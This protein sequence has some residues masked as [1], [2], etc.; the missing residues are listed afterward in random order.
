MLWRTKPVKLGSLQG[1]Q[2]KP[3]RHDSVYEIQPTSGP[4]RLVMTT[5]RD[6][7]GLVRSLVEC[8]EPP[9]GVLY[10]LTV[11][12][13]SHQRGRYQNT[14]S[15]SRAQLDGFLARFADALAC[16][17]RHS[18]WIASTQLDGSYESQV[19][20]DQ[21]DFVYAYGDLERFTSLAQARGLRPG[22]PAIPCPHEHRYHPKFDLAEQQILTE[23]E[24][25]RHDIVE[26]IDD[27]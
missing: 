27:P 10:V 5:R 12:R 14:H 3:H 24:W 21:H 6:P 7:V 22:R 11:S 19:I 16:D 4:S 9:F 17:G 1:E 18:I 20:Y 25:T 13:T 15:W 2:W 23:Y 8:M 26:E